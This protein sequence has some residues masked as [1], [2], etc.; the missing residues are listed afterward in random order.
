MNKSQSISEITKALIL[1]HVKVGEIVKDAKNP[2]F[3]STYATLQNI[4]ETI[5]EPLIECG[6]TVSQHPEGEHGLNTLLMHESGEWLESHYIMAPVKND[7]Q[8]IGSCITY[9]KRYALVSILNLSVNDPDDDGNRATYGNGSP[10]QP[11]KKEKPWLNKDSKQ[12]ADVLEK[13]NMSQVTVDK[14]LEHFRLS[15]EMEAFLREANKKTIMKKNKA[16]FS[17]S[18]FKLEIGLTT[19]DELKKEFIISDELIKDLQA[20]KVLSPDEMK[21]KYPE[22]EFNPLAKYP[23]R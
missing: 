16:S 14:V 4:Q 1:F 9:Q 8:G 23:Y 19:V 10:A 11:E 5:R 17:D 6:L 12:Y 2:F 7:P 20:V 13:V 21:I 3:K 22:R 18:V 15:K